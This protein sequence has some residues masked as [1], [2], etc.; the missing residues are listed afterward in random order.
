MVEKLLMHLMYES[1]RVGIKLPW[2][3]AVTRLC[4]GS[5][6]Q[7]AVQMLQKLRDILIAEGHMVPPLMGKG[8]RVSDKNIRGYVRDMSSTT[9]TD[10]KVLCWG[11]PW[12]D[13]KENL[14]IPDVVRGSGNYKKLEKYQPA[15]S[16]TVEKLAKPTDGSR[17]NRLPAE[18][19]EAAKQKEAVET[20]RKAERRSKRN[21]LKANSSKKSSSTSSTTA[22]GSLV[23]ESDDEYK[24]GAKRA[25]ASGRKRARRSTKKFESSDDDDH[26]DFD[27][28][29]HF[30]FD[31][32]DMMEDDESIAQPLNNLPVV[33]S[34]WEVPELHKQPSAEIGHNSSSSFS[35]YDY[36][37]DE[38][39][40]EPVENPVY[41]GPEI[42][43]TPQQWLECIE[44]GIDP[45]INGTKFYPNG[46][47]AR[48]DAGV[49]ASQRLLPDN[50]FDTTV[51]DNGQGSM[52][53]SAVPL[54]RFNNS[55]YNN[56]VYGNLYSGTQVSTARIRTT[57][58]SK[59]QNNRGSISSSV[60]APNFAEDWN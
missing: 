9:P 29:S 30:N 53:A 15:S 1:H 27:F 60:S 57:P 24:P 50:F 12:E 6:G 49:P 18:V 38:E 41:Q 20:K 51:V 5:T 11:D 35:D 2:D 31:D 22:R 26:N 48:F 23:G 19:I 17:R 42:H 36:D 46:L 47:N 25:K 59:V 52:G 16:T 55:A 43:G 32:H 10:V 58:R 33:I 14:I 3:Q 21:T 56:A 13:R 45:T 40:E 7:T 44:H 54:N 4:P 39:E 37:D 8:Q 28:D 34:E